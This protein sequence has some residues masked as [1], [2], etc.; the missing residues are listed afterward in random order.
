MIRR[1]KNLDWER[2]LP[3]EDL[4]YIRQR[5]ENDA[6]YP[7]ATFERLGVAILTHVDGA[8]LDAVRMWGRFSASQQSG[9]RPGLIAENDP[10]ESLMRLKVLRSTFFNFPAFDVPMLFGG[11]AHV[12]IRYHM[13]P[14]AEEAAC[15][16][17]M[18]FCEGVLS[19][20]GATDITASFEQ[21]AW[22]GEPQTLLALEWRTSDER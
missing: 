1:Q 8:T 13:G 5:I 19:L 21:R 15:M 16:Q 2:A 14:I 20:A 17:T 4:Q 12:V 22:A 6:W 3:P 10:V 9:E 18:G 11:H 7:M